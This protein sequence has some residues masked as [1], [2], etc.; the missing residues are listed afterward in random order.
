MSCFAHTLQ[1]TVKDG[2]D[3]SKQITFILSKA[4]KL[5]R[6]IRN[7]TV[8]VEKLE[9]QTKKGYVLKMVRRVLE[10]DL[11]EPIPQFTDTSIGWR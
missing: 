11:V 10:L 7:S 4:S 1:L 8:A 6:Y 9:I 5:V 3:S 2:I